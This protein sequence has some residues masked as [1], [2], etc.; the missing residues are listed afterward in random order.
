[1][2]PR[3]TAERSTATGT[4]PASR[5]RA[6]LESLLQQAKDG[7]ETAR[8]DLLQLVYDE[9]HEAAHRLMPSPNGDTL[10]PTALVNELM[11]RFL[12]KPGLAN[13]RN[14]KCFFAVAIDAM[15]FSFLSPITAPKPPVALE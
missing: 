8:H 15:A 5:N 13:L 2:P 7:N 1:M 6:D 12:K 14:C 3:T 4:S 9:L 10:Q 11:V